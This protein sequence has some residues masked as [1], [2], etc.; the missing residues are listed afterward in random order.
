MHVRFPEATNSGKLYEILGEG[1]TKFSNIQYTYD[2]VIQGYHGV[3]WM[4][5]W[6]FQTFGI[7]ALTCENDPT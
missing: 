7:F 2:S 1:S 3:P 5:S 4:T 6:W